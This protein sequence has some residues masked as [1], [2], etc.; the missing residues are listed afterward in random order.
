M[1][2]SYY[3][4][5]NTSIN[6]RY[7]DDLFSN[8]QQDLKSSIKTDEDDLYSMINKIDSTNIKELD[9]NLLLKY[10]MLNQI[11]E[12]KSPKRAVQ[13]LLDTENS[14]IKKDKD[15]NYYSQNNCSYEKNENILEVHADGS[16]V[17]NDKRSNNLIKILKTYNKE[18]QIVSIKVTDNLGNQY[19][20]KNIVAEIIGLKKE[21]K[22][23]YKYSG[24]SGNSKDVFTSIRNMFSSPVETG[25]YMDFHCCLYKWHTSSSNFVRVFS[26]E[27]SSPLLVDI[28]FRDNGTVIRQEYTG[29]VA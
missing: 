10:Y 29:I 9:I 11:M 19:T 17:V 25:Y 7:K 22:K 27:V 24:Y 26:S 14:S 21:Y 2:N 20:N 16:Y 13:D 8:L 4:M 5:L 15:G 3:K 23:K 18:N 12:Y 1:A 6:A 28:E